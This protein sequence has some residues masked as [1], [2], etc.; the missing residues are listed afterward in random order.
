LENN[1]PAVSIMDVISV[2]MLA[3]VH[4]VIANTS[5]LQFSVCLIY[6]SVFNNDA[7]NCLQPAVEKRIDELNSL[8]MALKAVKQQMDNALLHKE[9]NEEIMQRLKAETDKCKQSKS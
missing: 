9:K 6:I 5:V 7:T 8:Q 2:L 3:C 4:A 1:C